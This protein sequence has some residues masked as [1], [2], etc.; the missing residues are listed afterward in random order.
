MKPL[1]GKGNSKLVKTGKLLGVR[2]FNFS[3]P[4]YKSITGRFTCPFAK[5]CVKF[6][7]AQ[8][9][10]YAWSNTQAALERRYEASKEGTFVSTIISELRRVRDDGRQLYIRM[11]DSG[12]F[13]SKGYRDKWIDIARALPQVRFYAYTKSHDMFRDID[14]PENM[15][16]IMSTGSSL[17]KS[18]DRDTERHAQIFDSL[19]ELEAAGYTNA[20]KTDLHATKWYTESNKI[21]LVLH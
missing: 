10:A 18:L 12:D 5:D 8:K 13:Y 17:D 7:Y 11:H 1:L 2:I 6:C 15:D 20:S 16:I 14:M 19:E 21:G 4:A 3:I 9:G